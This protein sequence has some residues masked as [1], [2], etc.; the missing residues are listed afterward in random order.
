LSH[1]QRSNIQV[2]IHLWESNLRKPWQYKKKKENND[3]CDLVCK[4]NI[5]TQKKRNGL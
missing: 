1:P 4:Y 3:S 5:E 2:L